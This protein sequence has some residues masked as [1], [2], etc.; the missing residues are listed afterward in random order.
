MRLLHNIIESHLQ[1]AV[2][3]IVTQQRFSF[4]CIFLS[5]FSLVSSV[6]PEL[7]K[8]VKSIW[9]FHCFLQDESNNLRL[10]QTSRCWLLHLVSSLKGGPIN[11]PLAQQQASVA[12]EQTSIIQSTSLFPPPV[13]PLALFLQFFSQLCSK[14]LKK[15]QTLVRRDEGPGLFTKQNSV[16]QPIN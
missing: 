16:H 5:S 11:L 6:H 7:S 4:L 14:K 12:K 13:L 3:F 15:T 1:F 10:D 2:Y 9:S 8:L